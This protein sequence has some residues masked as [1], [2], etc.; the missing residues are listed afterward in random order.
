MR[1]IRCGPLWDRLADQA[2]ARGETMTALVIRALERE[3]RR[4][5][6]EQRRLP[7]QAPE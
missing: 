2:T 3:E 4:L 6:R 7:W 1:R 5:L